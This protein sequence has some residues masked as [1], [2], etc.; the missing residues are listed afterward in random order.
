MSIDVL[1]H[2]SQKML[3]PNSSKK[4]DQSNFTCHDPV[5][6]IDS[7]FVLVDRQLAH[8]GTDSSNTTKPLDKP[9]EFIATTTLERTDPKAAKVRFA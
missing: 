7:F 8:R 4:D 1:F 5:G 3:E 2:R 6:E 9:R